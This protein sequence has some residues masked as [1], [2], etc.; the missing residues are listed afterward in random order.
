MA[1]LVLAVSAG[2]SV[3]AWHVDHG[4]RP[5]AEDEA[6]VVSDAAARFGAAFRSVRA[7]VASG[8]NLEARARRARF[9]ALPEGV[10]TGH[11][12]DDQAETLLIALLRGTGVDGLTG[13]DPSC[14][15]MLALRRESTEALC[16]EEGLVPVRDPTNAELVLVRNRIRHELLPL[17]AEIAGRDVVA[18]LTRT[19]ALVRADAEVLSATASE[20]DPTDVHGLTAAPLASARRALRAWLVAQTPP[21]RPAY[22]PSAAAIERVLDV[23]RGDAVACEVAGVGRIARHRQRLSVEPVVPAPEPVVPAP[24]PGR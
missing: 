1:L 5:G 20:I 18:L 4:L 13:M 2:C 9:D 11:T 8:P 16:A 22:P 14:H 23:A 12:A 24:E 6:A 3:T 19:A 10:L 7:V 21:G 15:P 17:A